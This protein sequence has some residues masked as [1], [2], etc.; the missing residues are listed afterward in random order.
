MQTQ[1][2]T[3]SQILHKNTQLEAII[4]IQ[5]K[6]LEGKQKQKQKIPK[7]Q[8]KRYE[9]KFSLFSEESHCKTLLC[10]TITGKMF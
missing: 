9:T 10:G 7:T 2:H 8:T 4:N 5:A 6:D 3:H 1:T